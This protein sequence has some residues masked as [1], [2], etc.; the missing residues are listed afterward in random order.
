MYNTAAR[1]MYS[2]WLVGAC[3]LATFHQTRQGHTEKIIWNTR[4]KI[5]PF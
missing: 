1:V 2:V 5:I 3:G 4:Y